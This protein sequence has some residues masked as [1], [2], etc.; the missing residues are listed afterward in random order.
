LLGYYRG[1]PHQRGPAD[2]VLDIDS[3]FEPAH[4][5]LDEFPRL[6]QRLPDLYPSDD[7]RFKMATPEM[8]AWFVSDDL[9]RGV[10]KDRRMLMDRLVT[11]GMR[12][13]YNPNRG[14]EVGYPGSDQH[15]ELT[16]VASRLE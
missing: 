2:P 1:S 8:F 13:L 11:D 7:P 3:H 10:P 9:L 15:L 6:Q 5:W 16:G 4:D 12:A 14:P